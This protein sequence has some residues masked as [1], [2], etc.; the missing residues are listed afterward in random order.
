MTSCSRCGT[1]L[2]AFWLTLEGADVCAPCADVDAPIGP[3]PERET[4]LL[5]VVGV[6]GFVTDRRSGRWRSFHQFR[7]EGLLDGRV[8]AGAVFEQCAGTWTCVR[9]VPVL[10]WMVGLDGARVKRLLELPKNAW[11]WR[12]AWASRWEIAA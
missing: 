7:Q 8:S 2:V 3:P 6:E 9:A 11:R 10:D 4:R 12:Y 1:P 5:I